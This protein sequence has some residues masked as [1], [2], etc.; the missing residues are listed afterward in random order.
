MKTLVFFGAGATKRLNMPISIDIEKFFKELSQNSSIKERLEKFLS[1]TRLFSKEVEEQFIADIEQTLSLLYDGNGATNQK[2]AKYIKEKTFKGY[3]KTLA[4][5]S[6]LKALYEHFFGTYVFPYYDWLA[7]KSLIQDILEIGERDNISL[8]DILTIISK[9]LFSNISIPTK[10]LFPKEEKFTFPNRIYLNYPQRLQGAVRVYNLLV[11][12]L[13][14]YA[15]E[16]LNEEKLSKYR[17]F[18]NAVVEECTSDISKG[19]SDEEILVNTN[20]ATL[21][22]EPVIPFLF[23]R[24]VRDKNQELKYKGLL[25]YLSYSAPF[26]VFNIKRRKEKTY[27]VDEDGAFFVNELT[28]QK[29]LCKVNVKLI[30]FFVPH[31]LFNMRVCPRCQNIFLIFPDEVGKIEPKRLRELFYFDIIPT[32]EDL[33]YLRKVFNKEEILP[34][35]IV[36]PHCGNPT[37]FT[38]TFL[39][40]QT[41]FKPQEPP[42]IL[43]SYYDYAVSAA[44]AD[45][46]VFIG[47]SFPKDDIPHLITLLSL[48]FN[49]SK[50]KRDRKMTLIL[51]DT[52]LTLREKIWFKYDEAIKKTNSYNQETLRNASKLIKKK[53]IR[54]TFFGFPDILDRVSPKEILKWRGA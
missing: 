22:W 9:A 26:N 13:F 3:I 4:Q 51:Y 21:N 24:R 17:K 23:I 14:K 27:I 52:S 16:E 38:D 12:K 42:L 7:L 34:S 5:K 29:K 39:Q 43:K 36:C 48:G 37:F 54:V 20:L 15:L 2:E 46:L 19:K 31:G 44:E 49:P 41:V 32:K 35:E 45:H 40:I 18:V 25:L 47:Y 53:N 28:K 6:E 8:Q 33:E 1:D 10:E 50:H 11:F 30:K